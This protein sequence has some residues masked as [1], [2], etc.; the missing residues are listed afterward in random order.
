M[1]YKYYPP[2]RY[3][4]EALQEG[5]FFFNKVSRQNDPYDASFK[6]IQ[7]NFLLNEFKIQGLPDNAEEIMKE[8]GT[9]SFTKQKNNKH[10]WASYANNYA[11]LVI[12]FEKNRFYDYYDYNIRIPFIEVNYVDRPI[13]EEDFEGSFKLVRPLEDDIHYK[14]SE[15][16]NDDRKAD[17]LFHYI[18]CLKERA[19]WGAEEEFRLIAAL[20]VINRRE[21]L[22]KKGFKYLDSGY[23]IPIPSNCVKEIIIGHNFDKVNYPII[24]AIAEK[25]N[26]SEV[27]QTKIDIPFDLG[28]EDVSNIV[29]T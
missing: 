28:M 27:K 11:G 22:E 7:A 26:I 14:F 16:L 23:K 19:S 9:C 15:C 29:L 8:Y 2:T 10:M 6:L 20:D 5:Y 24:K 13:V 18:C 17:Y 1:I 3:T 12:G 21:E 25:Y 4:Y